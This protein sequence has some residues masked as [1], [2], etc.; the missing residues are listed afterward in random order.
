MAFGGV[1]L[2]CVKSVI[3]LERTKVANLFPPLWGEYSPYFIILLF[4][5]TSVT[6]KKERLE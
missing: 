6:Y 1:F 5:S 2:I 4:S 3:T